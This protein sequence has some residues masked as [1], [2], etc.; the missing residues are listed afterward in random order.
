MSDIKNT[1][2]SWW[3]KIQI[4]IPNLNKVLAIIILVINCFLPGI[5]TICLACLGP[6]FVWQHIM[7]GLF[8]LLLCAIIIGWVWSILWGVLV[9]MK[10]TS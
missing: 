6:R 1:T 7:I 10:S 8:Q 9:V 3:D 2:I 4:S 5:G